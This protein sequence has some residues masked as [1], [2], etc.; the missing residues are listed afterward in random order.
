MPLATPVCPSA[1]RG[2]SSPAPWITLSG[3]PLSPLDDLLPLAAWH[4]FRLTFPQKI[5]EITYMHS[6]GILAGEL[7][8]G[9]LA[10]IDKQ[11]PAHGGHHE[12]PLLR[13]MPERPAAGHSPPGEWPSAGG[14]LL[15][16]SLPLM[17][18]SP[19]VGQHQ[20]CVFV[21][22]GGRVWAHT[23]GVPVWCTFRKGLASLQPCPQKLLGEAQW[24]RW[25]GGVLAPDMRSKE[26]CWRSLG[27]FWYWPPRARFHGWSAVSS[28]RPPSRQA[29]NCSLS[30][31]QPTRISD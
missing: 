23:S 21:S 26:V 12:G 25:P 19:T 11:M 17:P 27:K 2:L 24:S 6:E 28:T 4:W 9:P 3:F 30:A 7:K 18:T 22:A 15:S 8:H 10:L 29:T 20:Q 31:S 5:K 13:Q 16:C 14:P 1:L